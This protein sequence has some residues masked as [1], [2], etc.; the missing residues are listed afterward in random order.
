MLTHLLSFL[1]I[2]EQSALVLVCNRSTMAVGVGPVS[3]AMARPVISDVSV[4]SRQ[5]VYLGHA[6]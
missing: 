3:L 2:K 5:T 6:Q 4:N 1:G